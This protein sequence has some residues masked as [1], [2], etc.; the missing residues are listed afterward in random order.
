M[1]QELSELHEHER[2]PP[3]EVRDVGV[4]HD[5]DEPGAGQGLPADA[6][7]ARAG[8]GCTNKKK[9]QTGKGTLSGFIVSLKCLLFRKRR[10]LGVSEKE[11]GKE[12]GGSFAV[13]Q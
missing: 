4:D 12:E 1:V 11:K 5:G 3:V 6:A 8:D 9:E 2:V 7:E 13:C 10:D